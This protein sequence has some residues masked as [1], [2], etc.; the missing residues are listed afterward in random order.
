MLDIFSLVSNPAAF[1]LSSFGLI[2]EDI[3]LSLSFFPT[4]E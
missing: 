1:V 3:G 2:L 4:D